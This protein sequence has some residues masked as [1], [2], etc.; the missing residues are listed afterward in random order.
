ML[1]RNSR[2][3]LGSSAWLLAVADI[4]CSSGGPTGFNLWLD[5]FRLTNQHHAARLKFQFNTSEK[6]GLL[7]TAKKVIHCHPRNS[8]LR[9]TS[10]TFMTRSCTNALA[11]DGSRNDSFKQRITSAVSLRRASALPSGMSR[12]SVLATGCWRFATIFDD[13]LQ[14]RLTDHCPRADF[15]ALQ[16]AL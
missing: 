16:S 13:L 15:S 11:N 7:Q 10:A 2:R 8:S 9:S 12:R 3:Y 1:R 6:T 4:F 14:F 5:R